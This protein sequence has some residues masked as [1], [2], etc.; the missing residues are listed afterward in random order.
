MTQNQYVI[1]WKLNILEL[2]ETLGNISKA[3]QKLGVSRQHHYDIKSAIDEEGLEGLLEK[4]R[5]APRFANRVS[6]EIEQKALDYSLEFQTQGN[7]NQ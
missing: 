3:W 1:R 2:G 4:S 6:P 5:K 7:K